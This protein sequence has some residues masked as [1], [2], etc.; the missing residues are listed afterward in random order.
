MVKKI[1][2]ENAPIHGVEHG[3]YLGPTGRKRKYYQVIAHNRR[4]ERRGSDSGYGVDGM[5]QA[6]KAIARREEKYHHHR[7][8]LRF[9]VHGRRV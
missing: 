6:K 2:N 9:Y 8:W 7:T 3:S 1:K 5:R 4:G